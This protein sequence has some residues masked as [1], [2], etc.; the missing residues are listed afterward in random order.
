MKELARNRS[1]VALLPQRDPFQDV[2]IDLSAID[3]IHREARSSVMSPS[4]EN[5]EGIR[6]R[7]R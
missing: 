7:K 5:N 2:E 6:T 1:F 4:V 3:F